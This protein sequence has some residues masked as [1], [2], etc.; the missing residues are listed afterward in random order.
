MILRK[1]KKRLIGSLF[2]VMLCFLTIGAIGATKAQ[3]GVYYAEVFDTEF[4]TLSANETSASESTGLGLLSAYEGASAKLRNKV[5]GNFETRFSFYSQSDRTYLQEAEISLYDDDGKGFSIIVENM[6]KEVS[7]SVKIGLNRYGISYVSGVA[8]SKTKE[9]NSVGIYT[10]MASADEY[11]IKYE[12]ETG[13]V[14]ITAGDED[15]IL[16]WN[17][18]SDVND[19]CQSEVCIFDGVYSV[20]FG[21]NKIVSSAKKDK[22]GIILY[23]VNGQQYTGNLI[24]DTAS[25]DV[26]ARVTANVVAGEKYYLPQPEAFDLIDG[27]LSEV[28]VEVRTPQSTVLSKTLYNDELFFAGESGVNYVIEYSASDKSGRVGK[29]TREI[30]SVATK[31]KGKINFSHLFL[32]SAMGVG[33]DVFIPDAYATSNVFVSDKQYGVSLKILLENET[34]REYENVSEV[35]SNEFVF[36][37]VGLYSFVF[38]CE[39]RNYKIEEAVSFAI[40]DDLPTYTADGALLNE[41]IA[42]KE[43]ILPNLTV[44]QGNKSVQA[45]KIVSFPNGSKYLASDAITFED[46]GWYVLEY[47]AVIDGKTYTKTAS[48]KVV[49]QKLSFSDG[50]DY[51]FYENDGNECSQASFSSSSQTVRLNGVIDLNRLAGNESFAEFEFKPSQEGNLDFRYIYVTLSDSQ[52]PSVYV[53]IRLNLTQEGTN[54]DGSYIYK[55]YASAMPDNA[56]TYI[57]VHSNFGTENESIAKGSWGARTLID[58][59]V[60]GSVAKLSYDVTT[61]I[62]YINYTTADTPN[63]PIVDLDSLRYFDKK[64]N[65]FASGK[66]NVSIS[67]G[68]IVSSNA[69]FSINKLGGKSSDDETVINIAEGYNNYPFA[70]V[71]DPFKLL[72]AV[73]TTA[74]GREFPVEVSVVFAN[75]KSIDLATDGKYFVPFAEGQYCVVYSVKDIDGKTITKTMTVDAVKDLPKAKVN[76]DLPEKIVVGDDLDLTRYTISN[77]NGNAEVKIYVEYNGEKTEVKDKYAVLKSGDYALIFEVKDYNDRLSETTITFTCESNDKPT[78]IDPEFTIDYMVC[79]R[80]YVL[81]TL[82]A[83]D[84][85]GMPIEPKISVICDGESS[86]LNGNTFMPNYSETKD[87]IVRYVAKDEENETTVDFAVKAICIKNNGKYIANQLFIGENV[88]TSYSKSG[89]ELQ[90][91]ESGVARYVNELSDEFSI[92]FKLNGEN[93]D[94]FNIRLVDTADTDNRLKIGYEKQNG[95]TVVRI[96]GTDRVYYLGDDFAQNALYEL[97]FSNNQLSDNAGKLLHTVQLN[98]KGEDFEGFKGNSVFVSFEFEGVTG[99]VGATIVYLNNQSFRNQISDDGLIEDMFAP[100]IVLLS[101]YGGKCELNKKV[102]TPKAVAYDVLGGKVECSVSCIYKGAFVKTVGRN[103]LNALSAN[104]EYTFG[105]DAYGQYTVVFSAVDDNNKKATFSYVLTVTDIDAPT[106]ELSGS[107]PSIVKVGSYL[108]VPAATVKDNVSSAEN[109]SLYVN[110]TDVKG[111]ITRR[112]VGDRIRFEQAGKYTL[113]YLAYD[114]RNNVTILSFEIIAKN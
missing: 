49:K 83:C 69:V 14:F 109:I 94:K 68:E 10:T 89:I 97:S 17:V 8:Q 80:E 110:F 15:P 114:E 108:T 58:P 92:S 64:W 101:D 93:F 29:Y 42:E 102:N 95:K 98:E 65:G 11:A 27:E 81:P 5:C 7:A 87:I 25:P 33:S 45:E 62:V 103:E 18:E 61:N 38:T 21:F 100:Q 72:D 99:S 12:K 96:N 66:V 13:N 75:D 48:L 59:S 47:K 50:L 22:A 53:K 31:D 57:G 86:E 52:N 55:V 77:A 107:V 30:K 19:G 106:I 41:Y 54:S 20:K 16:I 73:A 76:F 70:K 104:E 79:G 3:A 67:V 44:G 39:D 36:E 91:E 71:G 26:Y 1:T 32:P 24:T 35:Y 82:K 60:N 43:Y 28:F 88:K 113:T 37:K 85:D 51:Y 105:F 63:L 40:S 56:D 46:E 111:N 74:N 34:I 84:G 90:A 4:M 2:V 6:G 9:N 23:S 112:K 78:F